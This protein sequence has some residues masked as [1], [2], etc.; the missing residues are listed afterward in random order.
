MRP[1]WI[2]L[3][4]R[5]VLAMWHEDL[6]GEGLSRV[7]TSHASHAVRRA[8][9]LETA[10]VRAFVWDAEAEVG[11][12]LDEAQLAA[13][14]SYLLEREQVCLWRGDLPGI[15]IGMLPVP[16]EEGEAGEGESTT[17]E[18]HWIQVQIVDDDGNPVPRVPYE[19]ELPSSRVMRGTTNDYG[20]I[21]VSGI[22][23]GSCK[24]RLPR[25]DAS[26]WEQA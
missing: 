5:Y 7:G 25:H 26:A 18:N 12:D 11:G 13:R 24:L 4:G 3:D 16:G 15:A 6:S 21:Y 10:H 22:D 2:D 9:A 14:L 19:L 1:S 23:P 20:V 8:R 17:A